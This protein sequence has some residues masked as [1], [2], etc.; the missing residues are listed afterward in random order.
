[1]SQLNVNH[2]DKLDYVRSML[3]QL[4]KMAEDEHCDMLAYLIE[5]AYIEASDVIHNKK[6]LN[7]RDEGNGTIGMAFNSPGKVKL[8]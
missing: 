8:Q 4:R 7:T 6:E 5:M 3:G 2:I 1:M